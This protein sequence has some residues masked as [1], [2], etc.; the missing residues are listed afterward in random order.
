MGTSTA[1]LSL[2]W[3]FGPGLF[4]FFAAGRRAAGGGAATDSTRLDSGRQ[5]LFRQQQ[6]QDPAIRIQ[7]Q[8]GLQAEV[9]AQRRKIVIMHSLIKASFFLGSFTK[10]TLCL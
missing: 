1:P 3:S 10:K 2:T 5:K 6:L 4:A 7:W 8:E 9:S